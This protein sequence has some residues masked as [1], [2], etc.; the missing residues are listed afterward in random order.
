MSIY[1]PYTYLIGWTKYNKWY[2]GAQYGKKA[3]PSNLWTIYF[4]SSKLLKEFR[5]KYGE[6]DI[7]QV[8]KVLSTKEKTLIWEEKV[9]RRMRVVNNEDWFNQQSA[10]RH[11]HVVEGT[12][13]KSEKSKESI[14]KKTKEYWNSPL[15]EEKKNRL[16][17]RNKSISF[18]KNKIW[19]NDGLC[20]KMVDKDSIP[21]GWNRGR[22]FAKRNRK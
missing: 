9:L 3:H 5:D 6:P 7:I 21:E 11:F 13:K 16:V 19:I 10:G 2:Y 15:G 4:T 12:I 17:E 1:T 8:R 22:L 14:S 18:V 20:H